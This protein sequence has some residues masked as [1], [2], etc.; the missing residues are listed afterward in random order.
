MDNRSAPSRNEA[1]AVCEERGRF[2]THPDALNSSETY[3]DFAYRWYILFLSAK[4]KNTARRPTV[5]ALIFCER[6]A[7]R[8]TSPYFL[9]HLHH[10]AVVRGIVVDSTREVLIAWAKIAS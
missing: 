8:R 1:L 5:A 9:R 10:S 3:F 6:R 2:G 7:C 4:K